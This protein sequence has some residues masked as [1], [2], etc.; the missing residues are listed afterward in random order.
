VI[1]DRVLNGPAAQIFAA[2]PLPFGLGLDGVERI[3]VWF[4]EDTDGA[5]FT[6]FRVFD[7][8]HQPKT[9]WVAGMDS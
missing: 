2:K 4:T 8:A 9:I 7:G 5:D 6:E 3:D 1:W